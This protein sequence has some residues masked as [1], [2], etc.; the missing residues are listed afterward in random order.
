MFVDE[1]TLTTFERIKVVS[2]FT[3][4]ILEYAFHIILLVYLISM[5]YPNIIYKG[6]T[7]MV[8]TMR[9]I[10]SVLFYLFVL[11]D[12]NKSSS[13]LIKNQLIY[14]LASVLLA[15]VMYLSDLMMVNSYSKTYE[16]IDENLEIDF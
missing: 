8:F 13:E 11:N 5:S 2:M 9:L 3:A 12:N 14:T 15:V 1:T 16:V 7:A 4:M 10:F 6:T